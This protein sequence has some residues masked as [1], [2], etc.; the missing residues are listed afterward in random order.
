MFCWVQSAGRS[1][2]SWSTSPRA[3]LTSASIARAG[4]GACGWAEV[5]GHQWSLEKQTQR[6]AR[7]KTT[8]IPACPA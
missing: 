8:H 1:L 2:C 5:N 3:L 7:G 4:N 6:Q